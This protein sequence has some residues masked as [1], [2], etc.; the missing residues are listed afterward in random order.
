MHSGINTLQQ[1]LLARFDQGIFGTIPPK[2][3]GDG[4]AI[5][6][7][8]REI[9]L[10][11]MPTACVPP[12]HDVHWWTRFGHLT[13]YGGTYYSYLLDKGL[14]AQIWHSPRFRNDGGSGLNHKIFGE[15][16]W[17]ELLRPGASVHP[18]TLLRTTLG[19]RDPAP[20]KF[21]EHK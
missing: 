20:E 18:A 12:S 10:T 8:A 16:V 14:A 11:T 7:L 17:H 5:G 21:Y 13:T 3:T 9:H 4:S 15:V 2:G 19:G 1:V 6:Q